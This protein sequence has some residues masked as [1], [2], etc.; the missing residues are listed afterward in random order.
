MIYLVV[1]MWSMLSPS[2]LNLMSTLLKEWKLTHHVHWG[3][4]SILLVLPQGLVLASLLSL[5]MCNLSLTQTMLTCFPNLLALRILIC[6]F[7]SLRKCVCWFTCRGYQLILWEWNSF[8]LL[9]NMMLRDGWMVLRLVVLN[10][11]IPLLISSLRD[12]SH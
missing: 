1:W 8:P 5:M 9:L 4:I 3:I 11:R 7:V 6:L 2:P 10:L 12:L